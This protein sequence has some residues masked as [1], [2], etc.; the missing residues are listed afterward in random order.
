MTAPCGRCCRSGGS[1]RCHDT[2]IC[3]TISVKVCTACREEKSTSLFYRSRANL[4]GLQ[5]R[6]IPCDKTRNKGR[7][8]CTP[9]DTRRWRK[10][11]PHYDQLRSARDPD[12]YKRQYWKDPE[13]KRQ[14]MRRWS[15]LNPDKAAAHAAKRRAVLLKATPRWLTTADHAEIAGR[16]S[17]AA[18][19]T[20]ITGVRYE[21]DH[22][23]PL[24]GRT[25][26]GL[27][28]PSN[29]RVVTESENRR[30]HNKFFEVDF[31]SCS[32]SLRELAAE[33]ARLAG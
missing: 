14:K 8:R 20:Q 2:E 25:A 19:M 21:V 28:V 17:F 11:N 10:Q 26:R 30:K 23:I 24:Q 18:L 12:R 7:R 16:Y 5:Y 9:E 33:A 15:K 6:C 27:H 29:L 1:A 3:Y 22:L 13:K 4:D 31:D 32:H